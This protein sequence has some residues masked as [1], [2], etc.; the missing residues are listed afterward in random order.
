MKVHDC[1]GNNCAVECPKCGAIY[2]VSGFLQKGSRSCPSCGKST[3]RFGE[4]HDDWMANNRE[5]RIEQE[6]TTTRLTFKQAWVGQNV[7][8][9]FSENGDTYRY[10]HDQVLQTL[11][12]KLGIIADTRSWERERYYNIPRLSVEQRQILRSYLVTND[13][14]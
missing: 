4:V 9:T 1:F 13:V 5:P 12:K 8:V 14:K 7:W 2:V 3:A 11:I 10:P 6:Q